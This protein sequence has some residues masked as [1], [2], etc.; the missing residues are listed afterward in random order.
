MYAER[1]HAGLLFHRRLHDGLNLKAFKTSEGYLSIRAGMVLCT[2]TNRQALPDAEA[3]LEQVESHL[4]EAYETNLI[5]EAK[6][7]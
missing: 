4:G 7:G 3:L 5:T 1:K 2:L 6:L